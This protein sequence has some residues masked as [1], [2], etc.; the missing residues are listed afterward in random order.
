MGASGDGLQ[1]FGD[2][3]ARYSEPWR[4]YHTLQHL[5]ECIAQFE[6]VRPLAA[7]PAE[8]EAALWFHDAVYDVRRHDNEQESA[9]LADA[10]L[11]QAGVDQD[12]R[13][14]VTELILATRHSA[15]PEGN[16]EMLLVDVDLSILGAAA[17]RFQEYEKQ[18]R[19]EY[20]FV[21]EAAFCSKRQ[22]ILASLMMRPRIYATAHFFNLLEAQ[23]R[24][25]LERVIGPAESWPTAVGCK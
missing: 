14:R 24:T 22:Q 11:G 17:T 18:I 4:R 15:A 9:R 7:R 6:P 19:E 23:A 21:P 2:L 25:N 3:L 8:I 12:V 1:L 10:S 20:A 5:E 13:E 16:D